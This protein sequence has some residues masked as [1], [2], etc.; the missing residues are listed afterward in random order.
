MEIEDA[1]RQE[2]ETVDD[3][4]TRVQNATCKKRAGIARMLDASPQTVNNWVKRNTIPQYQYEQLVDIMTHSDDRDFMCKYDANGRVREEPVFTPAEPMPDMHEAM[5]IEGTVA[6]C[7]DI[8]RV[9]SNE[10]FR[11]V[12]MPWDDVKY[13]VRC[14]GESMEPRIHDGDYV[15]VGQLMG[16]YQNFKPGEMY[17]LRTT[18][19]TMVKMVE[20]P[21]PNCDY[22]QLSTF[23]PDYV[24]ANGG[25]LPKDEL[26]CSYKVLAVISRE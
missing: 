24:L 18:S 13:I 17:L 15:G 6:T 10:A 16:K 22:L 9:D 8:D 3:Y 21:S 7:G 5:M 25:R 4:L 20:D 19:C 23:N 26:I 11:R 14:S 2:Y 1:V 12:N